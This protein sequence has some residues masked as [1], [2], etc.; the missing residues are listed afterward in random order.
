MTFPFSPDG[1]WT[2]TPRPSLTPIQKHWL[3]RPGAL[4]AGLRAQGRMTLRVLRE[5]ASGLTVQECWMLGQAA[6]SPIWMREIV[7]AVDGVDSVFARSFTP[8]RDAHGCWQGMRQLRARPLADMLYH[9]PRI[10]RSP[11]RVVRL[12]RQDPAYRA[13]LR[14]LPDLPGPPPL[15]C[16]VLARCSVFRLHARPLLVME[17]FLPAFWTFA[18]MSG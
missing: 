10:Q 14:L 3:L 5:A 18:K 17:C 1:R 13:L 4:T 9:D 15:P 16:A 12:G 2:A 7:M 6:G 8:L 11:F